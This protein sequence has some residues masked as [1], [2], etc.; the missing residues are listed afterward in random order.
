MVFDPSPIE[1][2]LP[3]VVLFSRC[4]FGEQVLP[5]SRLISN[6]LIPVAHI[7]EN[8]LFVIVRRIMLCLLTFPP[9]FS[10]SFRHVSNIF[11]IQYNI[12]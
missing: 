5:F 1:C 8:G 12:V 4:L 2:E 11:P 3:T 7:N 9:V 10:S 6:D